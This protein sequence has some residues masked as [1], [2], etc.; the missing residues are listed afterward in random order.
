MNERML[1]LFKK[2]ASVPRLTPRGLLGRALSFLWS[3][4]PPHFCNRA[5]PPLHCFSAFLLWARK[6]YLCACV[7][8]AARGA[9]QAHQLVAWNT[10]SRVKCCRLWIALCIEH[11]EGDWRMW[12]RRDDVTMWYVLQEDR[13]GGSVLSDVDLGSLV[14]DGNCKWVVFHTRSGDG[15]WRVMSS[16][17]RS[18]GTGKGGNEGKSFTVGEISP[19]WDLENAKK[20]KGTVKKWHSWCFRLVV[21]NCLAWRE[22]PGWDNI[23]GLLCCSLWICCKSF[24]AVL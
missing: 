24:V 10:D 8:H 6:F 3:F 4:F 15:V 14:H 20:E 1:C 11:R 22:E 9:S 16:Y 5:L 17:Q 19:T 7:R 2:F 23:A 12:H 18:Q 21:V 13:K